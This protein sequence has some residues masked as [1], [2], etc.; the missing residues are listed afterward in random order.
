MGF[1]GL[2]INKGEIKSSKSESLA[3]VFHDGKMYYFVILKIL[4]I[5]LMCHLPC[6]YKYGLFA[7]YVF[8]HKNRF[9]GREE[10]KEDPS[11]L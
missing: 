6:L 10:R 11:T 9:K 4:F 8:K 5:V 1:E 2:C 7:N 3:D